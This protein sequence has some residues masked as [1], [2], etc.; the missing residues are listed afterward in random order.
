[1]PQADPPPRPSLRISRTSP[2]QPTFRVAQIRGL[3]DLPDEADSTVVVE[4]ERPPDLDDAADPPPW[5]IGAIVGPSG[6]GKSTLATEL[7]PDELWQ[8]GAWPR[9]RSILD[10]FPA[11]LDTPRVTQLLN[12]VGFSSPPAWLRPHHALSTGQRFRAELAL[13]LAQPRHRAVVDEFTSVVDRQVARFAS[14]AVARAVRARRA[15][16]RQFVAVSCHYD[17]LDWLSPDWTLDLADGRCTTAPRH[18]DGSTE[19]GRLQRPPITLELARTDRHA[20]RMFATHHYLTGSLHPAARC[21]LATIEQTPV[22]FLA[23]LNNAGHR[24]RRRVH[25]LVVLPD[26]QG[27]GVGLAVLDAVAEIEAR[28]HVITITTSHPALTRALARHP[29]WR[30]TGVNRTGSPQ[31]GLHRRQRCSPPRRETGPPPARPG[32]TGSAGRPTASFRFHAPPANPAAR[33][34]T[35]RG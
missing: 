29:R 15:R 13:A 8:G 9:D 23:T 34:D 19:R 32:V 24:G 30:L 3:F 17:I 35:T 16:V 18:G 5:T 10:A 14:A 7:F 22:A 26:Y 2:V 27:L 11:D 33:P 21:Y 20:W 28:H 6:A 12:A 25:R 31:T 1:M 4:A